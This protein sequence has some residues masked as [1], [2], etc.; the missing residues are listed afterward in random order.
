MA[1]AMVVCSCAARADGQDRNGSV[2]PRPRY[3]GPPASVDGPEVISSPSDRVIQPGERVVQ[4]S[5]RALA[6]GG[7]IIVPEGELSEP[8]A[9]PGGSIEDELPPDWILEEPQPQKLSAYKNSF[10]QKLSLA[11]DWLGNEGD[12]RDL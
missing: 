3:V 5:E 10:F 11:A 1:A 7:T 9:L 6:P 2:P 12:S 4:P 8:L